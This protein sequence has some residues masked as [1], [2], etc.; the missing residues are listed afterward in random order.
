MPMP[1]IQCRTLLIPAG[2]GLTSLLAL[3]LPTITQAQ[4][5]HTVKF[6][7][8]TKTAP[9]RSQ[10]FAIDKGDGFKEAT[11][12]SYTLSMD[13]GAEVCIYVSN[14]HTIN[15]AYSLDAKVDT[16][17][18]KLPDFSIYTSLFSPLLTSAREAAAAQANAAPE[19]VS[20][21]TMGETEVLTND[22]TTR[23]LEALVSLDS[24]AQ[25]IERATAVA[26]GS[27]VPESLEEAKAETTIPR[28]GLRYAQAYIA[29]SLPKSALRFND[30]SLAARLRALTDSL[31][32]VAGSDASLKVLANAITAYTQSLLAA[33]DAL[34]STYINASTAVELCKSVERGANTITLQITRKDSLGAREVGKEGFVVVKAVS[35]F[36]R[37]QISLQ[38]LAL[39]VHASAVPRFQ[40]INDTL[41]DP[42]E[43]ANEF[44]VGGMIS[45]NLDSFG[46]NDNFGVGIGA[47]FGLGAQGKVLSDIL[48][49]FVVSYRDDIR[50]GVGAGISQLPHSVKGAVP[51]RPLPPDAGELEDLIETD[52][53]GSLYLL[54][55]LPGVTLQ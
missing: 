13:Q 25:D 39:V 41:R 6:Y 24:L 1:R 11:R 44:R 14:A 42:H 32:A 16:S 17:S 31:K 21:M 19:G 5:R 22:P 18:P 20:R 50:I 49:A 10:V 52:W 33:R 30:P 4:E 27:D 35:R 3:G 7:H 37:S 29:D 45:L 36:E 40:V 34:H 47:G 46:D 12:S 8:G 54:L 55:T 26:K 38:P 2:T 23:I 43:E 51:N 28:A 9:K 53:K 15:Y 48:A